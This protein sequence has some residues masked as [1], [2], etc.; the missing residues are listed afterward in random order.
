MAKPRVFVSSTFYDLKHVRSS[1]DSFITS[2]GY[3]SVLSEKG[4]IAYSPSMALDESCYRDAQSCDIFVLI[5]GGRYG[6]EA[7]GENVTDKDDFFERYTSITKKE[8]EAASNKEV[9]IY[10]LID[11]SVYGE[12]E[13]YKC[14]KGKKNIDY[15]HVD[16]E[17][18]FV[19]IEEILGKPR[20]NPVYQFEKASEIEAWLKDQ[21]AGLFKD[22][23]NSQTEL[24]RIT[25]L[26]DQVAELENLNK[27]LKRYMEEIVEKVVSDGADASKIIREEDDRLEEERQL[28]ELEKFSIIKHL[29]QGT[30]LLTLQVRNIF[31]EA[32]S[33]NDFARM[34]EKETGKEVVAEKA[35]NS[36]KKHE[37]IVDEINEVRKFLLLSNLKFE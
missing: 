25:S 30:N 12:F 4:S 11:K 17:N 34:L 36:W 35:L 9:P 5:I 28:N 15:A 20:N 19:L 16:S 18:I 3:D 29:L 33:L 1:L 6:S 32:K 7:T 23:I 13:T 21:W 10:I 26:S 31:S 27:T 2:L 37:D 22:M 8:Y 24:L 14:N